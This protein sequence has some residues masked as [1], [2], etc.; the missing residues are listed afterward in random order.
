[1]KDF[2]ANELICCSSTTGFLDMCI[3]NFKKILF[4]KVNFSFKKFQEI[5]TK[6]LFLSFQNWFSPSYFRI[7][8]EPLDQN[9][10]VTPLWNNN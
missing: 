5:W 7:S 2:F 10:S 4:C 8:Q 3:L 1:M 6:S 9:S